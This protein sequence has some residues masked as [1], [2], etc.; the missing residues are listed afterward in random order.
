MGW[1]KNVLRVNLTAGSVYNDPAF[2]SQQP[3]SNFWS[4]VPELEWDS[5]VGVPGD[6]VI[7]LCYSAV[8]EEEARSIRPKVVRVDDRNRVISPE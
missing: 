2:D 4:I 8:S 3:Q 1:Q 6:P 7:I 5:W